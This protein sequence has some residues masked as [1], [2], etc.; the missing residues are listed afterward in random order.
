MKRIFT[1]ALIVITLVGCTSDM[2]SLPQ[3][4]ATSQV[5]ETVQPLEEPTWN[6]Y[7]SDPDHIWNRVFRQFYRRTSKD[8]T[9]YGLGELDPLLWPDTVY[10]LQGTSHKQAIQVL[11][12]FLSTGA[13][14]LIDDPHKR[15]FFQ[16]LEISTAQGCETATSPGS[17]SKTGPIR[18]HEAPDW[19]TAAR[20]F[21]GAVDDLAPE[22]AS[23][24]S[25][26]GGA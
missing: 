3:T 20:R 9:E 8:G 5:S 11:D 16:R 2:Q 21:A 26:D 18:S 6:V 13:E 12:E 10:L 7:D 17:G 23:T 15:A 4:T 14:S 19:E 24:A 1:I 22:P 25:R